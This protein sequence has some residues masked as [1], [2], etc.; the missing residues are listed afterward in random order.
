MDFEDVVARAGSFFRWQR[1]QVVL[2][3]VEGQFKA[4]LRYIYYYDGRCSND[5]ESDS[6][7]EIEQLD[8]LK[9]LLDT[10]KR[11]AGR[12]A[13]LHGLDQGRGD[14]DLAIGQGDGDA[15]RRFFDRVTSIALSAL[16]IFTRRQVG[17]RFLLSPAVKVRGLRAGG[18]RVAGEA[19]RCRSLALPS[20]PVAGIAVGAS[21]DP[22]KA[23]SSWPRSGDVIGAHGKSRGPE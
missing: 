12:V 19:R 8:D 6:H 23:H 13:D 15:G 11:T 14:G 3:H 7:T 5:S 10:R 2:D 18:V 22:R 4:E 21:A 20:S 9:L 16:G 1:R 17:Q